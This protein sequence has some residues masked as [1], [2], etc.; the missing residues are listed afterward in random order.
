MSLTARLSAFFLAAL[1]VVLIGFST[2]L[3]VLA[4]AYLYRRVDERLVSAVDTL[5]AAAEFK[6]GGLEWEPHERRLSIGEGAGDEP[7]RWA[8]RD[9]EGRLVT[10]GTAR[11]T[12]DF[13]R[14]EEFGA[15]A[16]GGSTV[17]HDGQRWRVLSRRL[18]P[19]R[20]GTGGNRRTE[21]GDVLHDVLV[22]TVAVPLRGVEGTLHTLAMTLAGLS[23][24][25]LTVAAVLG[26]WLS[27]RALQPLTRMAASAR[28]MS[29]EDLNERLPA[30]QTA[31]ELEDLCRAFNDLLGRVQ[32][33]FERQRR[34][35]GDASHQLRTPLTVMLGQLEVALRRP[36]PA[37]EYREALAVA[38]G[39]AEHLHRIVEMLLFLARADAEARLPELERTE[40]GA[41][42][43]GH[44]ESW[45]D[46]PRSRD[47]RVE[48]GPPRWVRVQ[49]ALLGQLLDNLLDNACKYSE[50]GT[51]I[52]VQVGGDAASA[53]L[54][55]EDA[56]SGIDATD[57]PHIFEPFYRSEEARRRGR[58]GVGLGLAVAARIAGALGGAIEVQ[59]E[60]GRGSRFVLRLPAD[61]L[62]EVPPIPVA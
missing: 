29:A 4:R 25:V 37:E 35:T 6:P 3:F 49:P 23:L 5:A 20:K 48:A 12:E 17:S 42:L 38:R 11:G 51:P 36:R 24:G 19:D 57:L 44:L 60:R 43:A 2:A 41:W 47:L 33:A 58:S 45:A 31:D 46:H 56:G 13:W 30:A 39:Q 52:T 21:Q 7:V 16:D 18:E 32:E 54:A 55:V 1:A 15:T 26:R 40:L 9:G 62:T 59:S 22:V 10:G 27:R 53:T 50:Q 8:V 34:F 61:A 14:A 28:S